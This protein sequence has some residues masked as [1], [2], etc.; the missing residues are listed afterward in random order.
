MMEKEQHR[1]PVRHI[2]LCMIFLVANII[3]TVCDGYH[4]YGNAGMEWITE[5]YRK[6]LAMVQDISCTQ[7]HNR[8]VHSL[9]TAL[10][11]F[12]KSSVL[13][14]SPLVMPL[15]IGQLKTLVSRFRHF[16]DVTIV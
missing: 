6:Q 14:I 9:H 3:N 10:I 15:A 4:T 11:N 12:E 1:Y 7:K 16:R 13:G 8:V 2:W 5:A